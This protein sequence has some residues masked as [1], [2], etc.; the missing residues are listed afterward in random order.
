[1]EQKNLVKPEYVDEFTGFDKA[2][3]PK[4]V[5]FGSKNETLF[6]LGGYL[7]SETGLTTNRASKQNINV[8]L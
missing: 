7:H 8:N 2:Q 1:M 3:W 5:Q 4:I 6:V